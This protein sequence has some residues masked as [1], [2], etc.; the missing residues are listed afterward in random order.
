MEGVEKR[1]EW[2]VICS[3]AKCS[4]GICQLKRSTTPQSRGCY[5]FTCPARTHKSF[6]WANKVEPH[7][8]MPV[9]YCGGCNAGVCRVKRE[10][11]GPN[12]GRLMFLCTIK[13]GQ[14]SCGYRVWQDEL[15]KM[16]ARNREEE[17]KMNPLQSAMVNCNKASSE[18]TNT[19]HTSSPLIE[20]LNRVRA[21]ATNNGKPLKVLQE[22]ISST[23]DRLF[24]IGSQV[25]CCDVEM[26]ELELQLESVSKN[27]E[28]LEAEYLV[29][30]KELEESRRL[31][32]LKEVEQ[33]AAFDRAS[34]SSLLSCSISNIS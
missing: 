14:G 4:A 30:S 33:N 1:Y 17:E 34:M 2:R 22:E 19:D 9:P 11:S 15:E 16:E 23:M 21:E 31:L 6:K 27:K 18:A 12:A 24:Q 7:E 10:T 3:N 29:V 26:K 25:S 8:W 32:E 20:S 13:E 28:A 5:F